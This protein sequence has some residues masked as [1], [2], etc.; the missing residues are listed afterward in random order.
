MVPSSIELRDSL[1]KNPN[2]KIDK[3]SLIKE[4]VARGKGTA[5]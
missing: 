1:P 5:L 2:G 4:E 3:V